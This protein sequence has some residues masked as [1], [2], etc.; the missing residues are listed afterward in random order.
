MNKTLY[1]IGGP[2][3]IGKTTV[4]Q[5]LK[6]E[7]PC[8]VFLDGDWCW[9]ADPFQVT[10]E[11]KAMVLDNICHLLG[12]FLRCTAYENVI[13]C[14]V[15]Q[16]QS[17]IDTILGRLDTAG[18]VVKCVSLVADESELRSRLEKDIERGLRTSDVIERSIA[19]LPLYRSLDT[20]RID[21]GA[22]MVADAIKEL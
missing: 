8:S 14:W 15:M 5:Q 12:N 20:H 19:R 10:E 16:E 9:D 18:C 3:G 6:R 22:K 1:L 13:F 11:T 4:G 21:T 7:L 17:I 2:M